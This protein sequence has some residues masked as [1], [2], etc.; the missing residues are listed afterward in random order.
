[1][2]DNKY[3]LWEHRHD[4]PDADERGNAMSDVKRWSPDEPDMSFH[5]ADNGTW[6]DH[7]DY[8]ALRKEAD[9]M[10]KA[11][12]EIVRNAFL[13]GFANGELCQARKDFMPFEDSET[14]KHLTTNERER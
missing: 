11:L 6:I 7:I 10:R 8:E 5:G 4:V 2:S 14:Y 3:G 1:M 13:D 12:P 9:E